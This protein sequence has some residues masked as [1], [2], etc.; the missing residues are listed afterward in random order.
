MN[1]HT[2]MLSEKA[3]IAAF[4]AIVACGYVP[5]H[6]LQRWNIDVEHDRQC[7]TFKITFRNANRS[8]IIE[9]E[10]PAKMESCSTGGMKMT[11]EFTGIVVG[12]KKTVPEVRFG[13]VYFNAQKQKTISVR[14]LLRRHAA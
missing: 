14:D 2:R 11:V 8:R 7:H 12:H 10:V 1:Q 4:E 5:R 9:I 3:S 13:D 6:E